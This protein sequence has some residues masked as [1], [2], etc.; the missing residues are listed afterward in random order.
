M[1]LPR[2][3]VSVVLFNAGVPICRRSTRP[4]RNCRT[5]HPSDEFF[6]DP[7]SPGPSRGDVV[8]GMTG[9]A[10][11]RNQGSAHRLR[12]M[13][14]ARAATELVVPGCRTL[15]G[16]ASLGRCSWSP[17]RGGAA[18]VEGK[19]RTSVAC[20]AAKIQS[21]SRDAPV[22]PERVRTTEECRKAATEVAVEVQP[23]CLVAPGDAR[24]AHV[25]RW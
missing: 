11:T 13:G 20:Q 16:R 22:N 1:V 7:L 9:P 18:G 12:N 19:A 8:G 14:G 15:L 4:A 23:G 2:P 5:G 17:S 25:E 21:L 3:R 10:G 24:T 6:S